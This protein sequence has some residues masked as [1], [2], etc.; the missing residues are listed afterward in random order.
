[1]NARNPEKAI[2]LPIAARSQSSASH[3]TMRATIDIDFKHIFLMCDPS[4]GRRGGPFHSASPRVA[5]CMC[6]TGELPG[7]SPSILV[8]RRMGPRSESPAQGFPCDPH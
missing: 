5:R 7:A 8:G 4:P 3:V 1:M 2:A 6:E